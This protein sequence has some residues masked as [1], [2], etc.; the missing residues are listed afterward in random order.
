MVHSGEYS[1][2][3]RADCLCGWERPDYPVSPVEFIEW[4]LQ[5]ETDECIL[6][7]FY[8]SRLGYG[9]IGNAYAHRT[10]L[11]RATGESGE[12]LEA[13]HSC[14]SRNCINKRHL[15][16]KTHHENIQDKNR[17]GTHQKGSSC[18][19]AKLSASDV[20]EIRASS[21]TYRQL[22]AKFSV[23][24]STISN[25]RNRKRWKHIE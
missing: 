25:V 14:R 10:A 24:R 8:C 22:S 16:W 15:S 4:A 9:R 6:W 13:A 12:G 11:Q 3:P 2:R 18:Y 23:S 20:K 17:D 7:P 21:L 1:E 19:N 5:R